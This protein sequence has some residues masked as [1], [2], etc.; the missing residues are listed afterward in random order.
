M[1]KSSTGRR[2]Y[3]IA[4]MLLQF[5]VLNLL[6]LVFTVVGFIVF[7]IFPASIAACYIMRKR[8]VEQEDIPIFSS[9]WEVYKQSFV[10]GNVLFSMVIALSL[11]L[12]I[13]FS[14]I[15]Y[16]DSMMS[17]I[18]GVGLIII[19]F[20]LLIMVF[21]SLPLLSI[22]SDRSFKVMKNGLLMGLANPLATMVVFII[23]LAI[24]VVYGYL[25]TLLPLFGIMPLLLACTVAFQK[26]FKKLG[27]PL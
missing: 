17:T 9:F 2:L 14:A 11:I 26:S 21:Y 24:R 13:D 23:I 22:T 16:F 4:D 19:V 5:I 1:L 3:F 6:W 25:P 15:T 27:Q 12:Y 18:V 7:G 20:F 10:R 8:I